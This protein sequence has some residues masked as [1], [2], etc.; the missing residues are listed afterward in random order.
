MITPLRHSPF[1]SQYVSLRNK[2]CH[3]LLTEETTLEKT[4]KWLTNS[5]VHSYLL[6]EHNQLL[7]CVLLYPKKDN[8]VAIFSANKQ[9]GSAK[10]L[11]IY[12]EEE[13]QKLSLPFLRA[14]IRED[15]IPAQRLFLS[16]GYVFEKK[17]N[18]MYNGQV[19]PVIEYRKK[20]NT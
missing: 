17:E 10:K 13:A 12:I 7:S 6:I 19:I 15:N 11:L 14:V 18:R 5:G 16:L 9:R 2:Y 3:L 1:V 20:R 8:E 4:Q